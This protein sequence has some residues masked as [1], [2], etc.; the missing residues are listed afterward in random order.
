MF[1]DSL[2]AW[3]VAHLRKLKLVVMP[4]CP[5]A[6][7]TQRQCVFPNLGMEDLMLFC[8]SWEFEKSVIVKEEGF[9]TRNKKLKHHH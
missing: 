3:W 1:G 2:Q 7:E 5:A 8:F 9:S 6:A 4:L